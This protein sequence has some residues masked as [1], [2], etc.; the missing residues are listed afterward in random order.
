M[1][2]DHVPAFTL[3]SPKRVAEPNQAVAN[4]TPRFIDDVAAGRV[5]LPTIPGVVQRL[6]AALRD[7]NVD[8]RKIGE[9]LSK[10]PVLSAKVLRVA[11]SAYF[12]G[13][14]SMASIDAAVG[15]IGTQAL[16]RLVVA[17]GVASG[18][19]SIEGIDLPVFWRDALVAATAANRLASILSADPE[20][21]Y[22][23]GLMHATGHLILCR[24]YPDIASAMFTGFAVVR[25]AELAAIEL[26][27]FGI[28]HPTVGAF[29]AESLGFPQ[30]VTDAI[31]KLAQ[32]LGDTHS[33]LELALLSARAL[34]AAVAQEHSAE[35]ALPTLP[36]AVQMRLAGADG[37]PNAAFSKLYEALQAV[38]AGF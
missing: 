1:N 25:G 34:A 36:P 15:M 32:P 11:N 30:S 2:T 9:A 3:V 6:M 35:V 37:Q 28:D 24:S 12:G 4:P 8:T 38:E 33:P 23:C 7:P 27:A 17:C 10:D 5:E 19:N 16:N 18:F 20:E 29:W 21:A 31:G 14:R 13:Q 22:V 26:E